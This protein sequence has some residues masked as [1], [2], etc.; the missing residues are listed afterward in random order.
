MPHACNCSDFRSDSRPCE[1]MCASRSL[2]LQQTVYKTFR[3]HAGCWRP[4]NKGVAG[5][6]SAEEGDRKQQSKASIN[7]KVG[8]ACNSASMGFAFLHGG[9]QGPECVILDRAGMKRAISVRM[10]RF[11]ALAAIIPGMY[12]CQI[13]LKDGKGNGWQFEICI[14][15]Q[16]TVSCWTKPSSCQTTKV[17]R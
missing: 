1:G 17:G 14:G 15:T 10:T 12:S 8:V 13:N 2:L 5:N 6:E 11:A 4:R 9:M 7:V 3:F 16:Q